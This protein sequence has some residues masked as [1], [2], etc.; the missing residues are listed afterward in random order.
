MEACVVSKLEV[1]S[2][3][4]CPS[5]FLARN[6]G[7][8]AIVLFWVLDRSHTVDHWSTLEPGLLP[9]GTWLAR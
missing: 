2:L 1:K 8:R 4:D 5:A 7:V 9:G 3:A 6:L